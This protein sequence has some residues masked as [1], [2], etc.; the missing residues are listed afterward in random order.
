MVNEEQSRTVLR[1]SI[2][3]TSVIALWHAL[4]AALIDSR[5]LG[6]VARRWSHSGEQ[7]AVTSDD[8]AASEA[9]T[10]LAGRSITANSR[11]LR[12]GARLSATI[13]NSG[14]HSRVYALGATVQHLVRSSWLYRW[15]TAEPEPDV[16]VIDL[17]ETV[18]IGPWLRLLQRT[19][20]WILPA[21]VSSA[22]FRVT[23]RVYTVI[24]TRPVQMVSL[25]V[26][27]VV[28]TLLGLQ[29]RSPESSLVAGGFLLAVALLALLG[30]R[31]TMTWADLRET[32]TYQALVAL[33]EPPEPPEDTTTQDSRTENERK[34]EDKHQADRDS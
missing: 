2:I 30:T 4:A 34:D 6:P 21:A 19:L 5:F 13:G 16:I 23:R 27:A 3:I 26:S 18:T 15:L 9:P 12:A 29:A 8:T 11:V 24:V 28:V 22:L 14:S 7:N 20:E 25:F 1:G 10:P 32:R 17:R 33:L 31:V